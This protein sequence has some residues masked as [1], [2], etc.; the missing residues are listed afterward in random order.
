MSMILNPYRYA[1][2]GGP[3]P[4][5][6]EVANGDAA[7]SVRL[8]RTGYAGACI[9]VRESSG[10]TETDIGFSDGWIDETALL[11][12]CGANDGLVTKWYDQSGNGY[13]VSQTTNSE[14]PVI[15]SG[16]SVNKVNGKPA[17]NYNAGASQWLKATGVTGAFRTVSAVVKSD[18]S[19]GPQEIFRLGIQVII[20]YEGSNFRGYFTSGSQDAQTP[21][22]TTNQHLLTAIS[23]I[24]QV[25]TFVDSVTGN[26]NTGTQVSS[27]SGNLVVGGLSGA[28]FD[29]NIQEVVSWD[30]DKSSDR[31]AFESNINSAF[32]VY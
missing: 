11:S 3:T 1:G 18:I 26:T 22:T 23:T 28:Y 32:S 12:H 7:F 13:D 5:L 15:V 4:L 9:R 8:L 24:S 17:L 6:D 31:A 2:A 10:N 30:D 20:R 14:Q 19:S 25:E 16:G 27:S 21:T 29:G